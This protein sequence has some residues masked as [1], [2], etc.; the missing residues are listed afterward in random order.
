MLVVRIVCCASA[1]LRENPHEQRDPAWIV[2]DKRRMRRRPLVSAARVAIV[3][4]LALLGGCGSSSQTTHST[5][6]PTHSTTAPASSQPRSATATAS[7]GAT[8]V[9]AT[10]G[11]VTATMHGSSHTPTVGNWPVHFTVT[12][13][14]QPARASVGYE[15]LLDG[16]I[17][18][19]R[20]HYTFTGSFSDLLEWPA[21]AV[22]YPLTLRAVITSGAT[23]INLDYPIQVTR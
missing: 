7:A 6:T 18:A 8:S 23:V 17:V 10:A 22:G 19:R 5:S 14:G 15:F 12:R 16:E 9:S 4:V 11:E 2:E 20:S 3:A 1:G 13:A 21:T